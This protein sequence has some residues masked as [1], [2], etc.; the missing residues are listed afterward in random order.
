MNPPDI[1]S[2]TKRERTDPLWLKISEHLE[3][4]VKELR[5][6]N[7]SIELDDKQTLK[8]RTEILV[9]KTLLKL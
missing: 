8:I 3:S 4:K 7:D 9:Y 2:L 1:F 5:E 6:R